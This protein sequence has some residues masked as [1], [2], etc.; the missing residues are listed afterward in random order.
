MNSAG[1]QEP[2][3]IQ[4]EPAGAMLSQAVSLSSQPSLPSLPS[5]GPRDQS[6][7]PS[8][9]QCLATLRA[10]SSYVSALAVDGDSLYSA[11][12]DGRIRVWPL[13]GGASGGQEQQQDD[14]GG[15]ATVVA[16]C[17]SSV[18]CLLAMGDGLVLSSHQ[19]GKIRAWRAGSRKDGSRRLAPR[20]VLPTCVDRLRTFLLPWSYVQ[21]RRHRWR[22]WVHHVDAATALAV[23]PDGALLY[24]A[25]WDRSLKAWRLPGFQ[26]AESVA[27]AHDDA[28]NAL[29]VSPDGHVYTGSA[30]KK[31]KAWRRQPERRSKHVLVQTMERHRSAV[32]ALA[33]GVDG[34][35][36][37]SGA[38]DRSVV[39]WE[40]AGDGRMEA[41]GTLRGH[42]KAILCLAAAGDVVCSGSA[43]RTVRV[44]RRGAE[45]TGYTCLAIL[46]GHGAPVKSLTLV[47]GRDRGSFGGGGGGS[48]LVCSGALD[49][50]VKIWSVL[51]PCLL[52]R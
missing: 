32:N 10:H 39:V 20:A 31:I 24:S 25:S 4:H 18:K 7:I 16:A 45:N 9:H 12:S 36:L 28:I 3:Q 17:D 47:Y 22:T 2:S 51:V 27:A 1:E 19:D 48:A 26:C 5:L 50:E 49:G 13:D 6:V 46:E 34:K 11:S 52:E 30:D 29:A 40:R 44:W 21:V 42:K 8:L 15:S 14:S 23:S 35:V 33:L 43:D 37:Y 38:C 41:T